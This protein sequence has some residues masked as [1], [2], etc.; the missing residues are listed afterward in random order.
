MQQV[1]QENQRVLR[2]PEPGIYFTGISAST[3]DYELRYYVR[4]LGDRSSSM[5]EILTRLV[6]AFRD[7]NIDMAFN[8]L[9]VFI[10]NQHSETE[11][12]LASTQLATGAAG[13]PASEQPRPG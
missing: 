1:L 3:F 13:S 5:D 9:D 7:N 12:H 8:Q 4:D 10:K 2:D 6:L 11:T